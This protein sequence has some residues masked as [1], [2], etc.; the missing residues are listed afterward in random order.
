MLLFI[1]LRSLCPWTLM[2][3]CKEVS[4]CRGILNSLAT[5]EALAGLIA[6][7]SSPHVDLRP[8]DP[9]RFQRHKQ[10]GRRYRTTHR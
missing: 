7:G 4:A 8:F 5:G 1:A 10:P 6:N 2:T 3:T 9:A